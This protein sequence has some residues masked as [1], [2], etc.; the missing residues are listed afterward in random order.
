VISENGECSDFEPVYMPPTVVMDISGKHLMDYH[1][2][3]NNKPLWRGTPT[4]VTSDNNNIY[5]IDENYGK[6]RVVVLKWDGTVGGIYTGSVHFQNTYLGIL[7]AL[8]FTCKP[9][10]QHA[11]RINT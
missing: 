4:K 10:K 5:V 6:D 3:N 2:D 9:Y 7:F 11:S 8:V 1:L